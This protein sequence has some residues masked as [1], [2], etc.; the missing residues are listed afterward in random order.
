MN[1]VPRGFRGLAGPVAALVVAA[2]VVL[3]AFVLDQGSSGS[4]DAALLIGSLGLYILLALAVIWLIV[5][6]V[7]RW[8]SR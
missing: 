2:L 8:R 3:L 6:A 5:A 7:L 4:R 1:T